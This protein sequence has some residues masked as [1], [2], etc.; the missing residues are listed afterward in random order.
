MGKGRRAGVA[1]CFHPP[2]DLRGLRSA[3]VN[4]FIQGGRVK[5]VYAQADAPYRMLPR[6]FGKTLCSQQRRQDGSFFFLCLRAL[7]FRFSEAGTLQRLSVPEHLRRSSTR[8]EAPGR[9]CRSWKGLSGSYRRESALTGPGFPTRSG[10]PAPRRLPCRSPDSGDFPLPGG[11]VRKLALF[12]LPASAGP[13]VGSRRR[14]RLHI[15]RV[16]Q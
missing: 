11:P 3:Y 2:Y 7:D 1:H 9:R 6:G 4:D 10:K 16:A 5:R 12:H 15:P 13:A 14:R 8:A